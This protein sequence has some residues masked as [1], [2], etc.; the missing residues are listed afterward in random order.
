ME[1]STGIAPPMPLRGGQWRPTFSSRVDRGTLPLRMHIGQR[2]IGPGRPA[3]I[4]GEIAQAHDG[5]L[6]IAH[7]FIDALAD[8]GVDAVKFQTHLAAAES[9]R[10]E[11]WRVHFSRQDASRYD[12]WRRMEFTREQWRGLKDHVEERGL[13]LLSSPFSIEAVDLLTDLGIVAWKV[14]SGEITNEPLLRRMA[15]TGL[16][17]IFSSGMSNWAD[18]DRAVAIA[19]RANVPFAVLQCTTAYP[20]PPER[21]GL[22]QLSL[23]SAR[24]RCPVGL[25]DHS[26]TIFAGLAAATLGASILE[27]HVTFHRKMFGP[28][29]PASLTP[30]EFRTLVDGVRFIERALSS[31]VDRDAAARELEPVSRVFGRSIVAARPLAAGT[32]LGEADLALKKPGTGLPPRALPEVIGRRVLRDLA[33]DEPVQLADL[34]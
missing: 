28:D 17:M 1:I 21:I 11:P 8:A 15:A 14:A 12:Y 2:E 3:F 27:L 22:E 29:V 13:I 25:S 9:T 19:Q 26:G 32:L 30:E 20:C 5:S 4:V 6:G 33:P 10:A 34:A 24:Y 31:P 16:P 7:A 18:L 23:L